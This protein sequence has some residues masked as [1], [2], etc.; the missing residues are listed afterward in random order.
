MK[1]S[2]YAQADGRR[3]T[4]MPIA[5]G[6]RAMSTWA[7]FNGSKVPLVGAHA[8]ATGSEKEP[9]NGQKSGWAATPSSHHGTAMPTMSS[10]ARPLSPHAAARGSLVVAAG[11]GASSPS[12]WTLTGRRPQAAL[13]GPR[14][15]SPSTP[16]TAGSDASRSGAPFQPSDLDLTLKDVVGKV[17]RTFTSV[18]AAPTEQPSKSIDLA[19]HLAV[20][21]DTVEELA[22]SL[23]HTATVNMAD[24]GVLSSMKDMLQTVNSRFAGNNSSDS[25]EVVELKDLN[26][27]VVVL[28]NDIVKVLK[29]EFPDA[30][31]ASAVYQ[32]MEAINGTMLRILAELLNLSELDAD[33]SLMERIHGPKLKSAGTTAMVAYRYLKRSVS[34][35]FENLEKASV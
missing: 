7:F 28:N 13:P 2:K 8:W 30:T 5:Y 26:A 10:F 11:G 25:E 20:G 3:T 9:V 16:G 22:V 27:W 33:A 6:E 31:S 18:R 32:P 17:K 14:S 21:M 34:L 4:Q 1:S 15:T 23:E 19:R 35:F 29:K 12:A 24:C